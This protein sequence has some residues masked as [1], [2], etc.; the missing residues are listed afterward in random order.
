[1]RTTKPKLSALVAAALVGVSQTAVADSQG[2]Q[3]FIPIEKLSPQERMTLK[4][5]IESLYH[6][7]NI[8]WDSIAIGL[9]E[10][11]ELVLRGRS[12]FEDRDVPEPSCWA[13]EP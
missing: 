6:N 4:P 9:N 10:K 2:P 8:D 5:R 13:T 7:M 12:T 11:G 3:A 1:M